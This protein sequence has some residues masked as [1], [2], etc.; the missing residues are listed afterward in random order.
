MVGSGLARCV[1]WALLIVTYLAHVAA[2]RSLYASVSFVALLSVFALLLTDWGQV[3]ASLAQLTAA[4]GHH[5]AEAARRE[6]GFDAARIEEDIAQLA[7]T[8]PGPES[9]RLAARIRRRL[10]GE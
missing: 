5:D 1:M 7:L 2:V 4:E 9:D 10:K 8:A 3:A 6:S